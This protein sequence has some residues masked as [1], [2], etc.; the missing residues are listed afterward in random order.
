MDW[1]SGRVESSRVELSQVGVHRPVPSLI[2]VE[3][4]LHTYPTG[5]YSIGTCCAVLCCAVVTTEEAETETETE[6]Q[7]ATTRQR[8]E[9]HCIEAAGCNN[10]LLT[11][12]YHYLPTYLPTRPADLDLDLAWA[13]TSWSWT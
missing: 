8:T 11:S 1:V 10:I 9:L 13:W 3:L 5:L 2:W 12:Q 6:A 4:Y 7:A